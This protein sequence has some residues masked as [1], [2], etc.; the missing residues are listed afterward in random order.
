M[1]DEFEVALDQ[2]ENSRTAGHVLNYVGT[3]G[4]EG[5][6]V[7]GGE[8]LVDE[9]GPGDQYEEEG[10]A[11]LCMTVHCHRKALQLNVAPIQPFVLAVLRKMVCRHSHSW[12][13][14]LNSFTLLVFLHFLLDQVFSNFHV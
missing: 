14:R 10:V 8:E 4:D 2:I 13:I 7:L 11:E 12:K 6:V 9:E 5:I 1:E 3:L